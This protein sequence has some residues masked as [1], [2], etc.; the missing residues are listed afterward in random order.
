MPACTL[1]FTFYVKNPTTGVW[2]D[3]ASVSGAYPFI[4]ND[5]I[6][7]SG[8]EYTKTID[9][10]KPASISSW[11]SYRPQSMFDLKITVT[12]VIGYTLT[13]VMTWKVTLVDECAAFLITSNA[14]PIS[15]FTFVMLQTT[16]ISISLDL[17][18]N[19]CTTTYTLEYRT[20]PLSNYLNYAST[21]IDVISSWDITNGSFDLF[22]DKTSSVY[23]P[24]SP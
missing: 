24:Y 13:Q 19:S 6:A 14:S 18:T 10:G 8:A 20:D 5:S 4:L 2:Q 22:A 21:P 3:Y 9:F 16:L 11:T 1:V 7:K 17:N 23:V 12:D 15:D